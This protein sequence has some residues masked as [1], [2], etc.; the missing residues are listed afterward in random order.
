LY[1]AEV[2]VMKAVRVSLLA[3]VVALGVAV[4]GAFAQTTQNIDLTLSSHLGK[5]KQAQTCGLL[6]CGT[7]TL[8][9]FGT[10]SWTII[11]LSGDEVTRGCGPASAMVTLDLTSGAGGLDVLVE[12]QIC[13]PGNS[14]G[15]PGHLT[16]FGNPLTFSG[17]YAIIA[18]TGVFAGASGSGTATLKAAGALI[19]ARATGT[20]TLP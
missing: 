7:T 11:P 16:S 17:T 18:G 19:R 6:P 9:G 2:A 10:A 20:L 14:H 1:D 5:Q 3:L 4:P 15:A 8:P 13:Y 12:G